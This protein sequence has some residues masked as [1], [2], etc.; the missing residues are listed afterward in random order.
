MTQDFGDYETTGDDLSEFSRLR[1][2][3]W[4]AAAPYLVAALACWIAGGFVQYQLTQLYM[5]AT[6][7]QPSPA[8]QAILNTLGT[9]LTFVG[10]ALFVGGLVVVLLRQHERWRR[11][12]DLSLDEATDRDTIVAAD[13]TAP[14]PDATPT[15]ARSVWETPTDQQDR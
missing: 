2:R 7:A 12:L 9:V 6:G 5:N 15:Y 4:M 1:A 11:D 8:R 10:L 3:S 14:A 13:L